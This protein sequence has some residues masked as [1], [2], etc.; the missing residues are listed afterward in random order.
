M[1]TTTPTNLP[2]PPRPLIKLDLD[3][4]NYS[5][6]GRDTGYHRSHVSYV[7][8]GKREYSSTLA[9]KLA[10]VL[11]VGY[12]DLVKFIEN[13]RSLVNNNNDDDNLEHRLNQTIKRVKQ[14]QREFTEV[15]KA[16][17]S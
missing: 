10:V 3:S 1:T 2:R 17:N 4:L 12:I 16:I 8:R 5:Q 15:Q 7:L 13:Q 6:L 11:G 14:L 9:K